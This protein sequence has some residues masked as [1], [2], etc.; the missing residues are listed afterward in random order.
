MATGNDP[1]VEKR[2]RFFDGQFLQDDD[3][4]VEQAYH[5]DRQRRSTSVV[6]RPRRGRGLLVTAGEPNT[7]TVGPGT[8]VDSDGRMIVLIEGTTVDL[9]IGEVQ[10][11]RMS[12]CGLV[13]AERG[14]PAVRRGQRR[15]HP[16]ARAPRAH[17]RAGRDAYGGDTPPVVLARWRST[18]RGG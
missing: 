7:V 13:C 9:P 14:G 12:S 3:F 17:G 4:N 2:T 18:R 5:L 11:Q 8:A 10:R 1:A 6:A 16:L 15:L